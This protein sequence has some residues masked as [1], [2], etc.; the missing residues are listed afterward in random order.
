MLTSGEKAKDRRL[1]EIFN[2]TLEAQNEQ[3]KE[4]HNACAIC[5]RP[6]T[7]FQA[8]QDHDH[9]CC[10]KKQRKYCGK[11][12]RGLLCFLCNKKAV[13]IIEWMAKV[14]IDPRK[15]IAYIESWT[16]IIKAK[17]GYAPKEKTTQAKK[18][19]VPKKQTSVRHSDAARKTDR[20]TVVEGQS[21]NQP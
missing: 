21:R 1:R 13:A 15:V 12:N 6:F 3:R 19:R 4:Q 20:A 17:G 7:Q 8:Y 11:C 10:P 9:D 5:G 14:G 16:E 18:R 2:T